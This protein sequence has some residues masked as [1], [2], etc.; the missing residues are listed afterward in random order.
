MDE[1]LVEASNNLSG[2]TSDTSSIALCDLIASSLP[3]LLLRQHAYAKAQRLGPSSAPLSAASTRQAAPEI[4]HPIINLLQYYAF[5]GRMKAELDKAIRHLA[6]A[7]VKASLRIDSVGETGKE[8]LR[9]L[10]EGSGKIGGEAVL[11]I[12][13]K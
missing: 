5:L 4:L 11:R 13:S 2:T 7:G 1:D 12:D 10:L 9:N 6:D 8:V 3:V